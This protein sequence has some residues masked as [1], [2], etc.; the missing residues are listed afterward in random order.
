MSQTDTWTIG[1]LLTWTT[2]YLEQHGSTTP[3]LDAELLLAAARNCER[4]VLYTAYQEEVN[5]N[6]RTAFRQLVRQRTTVRR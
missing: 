4:I 1:R 3:R 5:E 2:G 6:T